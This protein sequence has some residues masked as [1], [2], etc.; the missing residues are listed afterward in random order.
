[1]ADTIG[2]S[3]VGNPELY[4]AVQVALRDIV[5]VIECFPD[6]SRTAEVMLETMR[7]LTAT[8]SELGRITVSNNVVSFPANK[9]AR[10]HTKKR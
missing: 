4:K 9:S 2:I 6:E 3:V 8:L 1:M 7:L 5:T 10:R